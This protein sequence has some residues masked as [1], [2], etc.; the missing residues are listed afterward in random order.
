MHA[1]GFFQLLAL[2][3][4]LFS[5]SGLFTSWKKS[6]TPTT[7]AAAACHSYTLAT[8]PNSVVKFVLAVYWDNDAEAAT[9]VSLLRNWGQPDIAYALKLL[10]DDPSFSHQPVSTP[11][12]THTHRA[13]AL[14][15]MPVAHQ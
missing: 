1:A 15:A 3:L 5:G 12:H 6:T 11:P 7:A 9:A 4:L 8:I 14:R 10:S 13:C 2:L